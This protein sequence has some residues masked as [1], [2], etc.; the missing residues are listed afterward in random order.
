[1]DDKERKT[2]LKNWKKWHPDKGHEVK[3]LKTKQEF[4]PYPKYMDKLLVG[5][6]PE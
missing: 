1:M 2:A 5:F 4:L 6:S 3:S